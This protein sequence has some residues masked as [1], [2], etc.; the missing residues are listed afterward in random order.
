MKLWTYQ[1]ELVPDSIIP[2]FRRLHYRK[3]DVSLED[4]FLRGIHP[5][6]AII[7][8]GGYDNTRAREEIQA[9]LNAE[10]A[11][12]PA[13]KAH[14][15]TWE[16][17][18]EPRVCGSSCDPLE[19]LLQQLAKSVYFVDDLGY[20]QLVAIAIDRL[21]KT[22]SLEIAS[23]MVRAVGR[24]FAGIREL[25]KKKDPRIVLT[26]FHS[27]NELDL[28]RV[29]SVED[30]L[31][32]DKLLIQSGIG[33]Q[34][35]RRAG[36]LAKFT[37]DRGLLRFTPAITHCVV[38]TKQETEHWAPFLTYRCTI[39]GDRARCVPNLKPDPLQRAKAK[40]LA[41]DL[42]KRQGVYCFTCSINE[43][44]A[45]TEDWHLRPCFPELRYGE[46]KE[47]AVATASVKPDAVACYG[48]TL[49]LLASSSNDDLRSA[50]RK[51]G[52]PMTGKKDDLLR[53]LVELL[54]EQ[55]AAVEGQMNDFFAGHR[56]IRIG[57]EG[58]RV[59]S[60]PV[61]GDHKLR[62][63]LLAIYCLRHMRGNV[64]LE[65]SHVNESVKLADLAE[66]ILW[67]R[68]RLAGSFVPAV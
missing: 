2:Q 44:E 57:V 12:V 46:A 7:A 45:A 43:L 40:L 61:L 67:G 21:R 64:I 34:N 14:S 27:L 18:I 30:F 54:A 50:L 1:L 33:R 65:A 17:E 8:N 56:F 29:V 51:F 23:N 38:A 24:D 6:S 68:V 35:F 63:L 41:Q 58:S 66:A 37:D 60:F 15:V 25:L 59:K 39:G 26:G 22:W 11:A 16:I 4:V 5:H 32:E 55:Y 52:R 53:R 31:T 3:Q 28:S 9:S 20:E 47:A 62:E 36:A 19:T 42:G 49:R 48:E 13:L 10:D